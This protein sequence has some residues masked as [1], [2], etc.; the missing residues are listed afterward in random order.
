[1]VGGTTSRSGRL[2]GAIFLPRRDVRL[3]WLTVHGNEPA[4]NVVALARRRHMHL[5]VPGA[6]P[7][8]VPSANI[9]GLHFDPLRR[10]EIVWTHV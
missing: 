2:L 7:S 6:P 3:A 8:R 10:T 4:G 1:M 9:P 5:I